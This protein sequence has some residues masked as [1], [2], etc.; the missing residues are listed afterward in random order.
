MITTREILTRGLRVREAAEGDAPCRTITGYAI[1]FGEQS[2]D[3]SFWGDEEIR[4]VIAPEAVTRDL[5]DSSDIKMTMFHNREILLARSNRGKGSLTYDIDDHG[6]SFSFDAPRTAEGDKAL[7]AVRRGDIAGCSFA[8]SLDYDDDSSYDKIT[9]TRAGKDITVIT[10]R[11]I[12]AVHDF[13]LAADPAYPQTEVAQRCRESIFGKIETST[14]EGVAGRDA[15]I[16]ALTDLA[17]S[18]YENY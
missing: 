14:V 6:V 15:D 11:R 4:E 8:F 9:E 5:L 2:D 17:R 16:K 12:A 18:I 1:V 10:V 7:E 13:T 3:L